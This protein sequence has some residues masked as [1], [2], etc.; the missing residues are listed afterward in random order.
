[1]PR[2]RSFPI[3]AAVA[4]ALEQLRPR[5]TVRRP[6]LLLLELAA[7]YFLYDAAVSPDWRRFDASEAACLFAAAFLISL[8]RTL[9]EAPARQRA[10]R[11]RAAGRGASTR[12]AF[13]DGSTEPADAEHLRRGDVIVVEA[14][15]IIPADGTVIEGAATV[16]ES[17]LTGESA[18][19]LREAGGER[20]SVI[21]GARVLSDVLKI[22]VESE[23]GKGFLADLAARLEGSL[24][25][26]GRREL[27]LGALALLPALLLLVRLGARPSWPTGVPARV[28]TALAAALL[29]AS[30][31][32]LSG[33]AGPSRVRRLLARGLLPR[34]AAALEAATRIDALILDEDDVAPEGRRRA[35][36]L[37]AAEGVP[38]ALLREAAQLT[39]LVDETP[40]GR[41]VVALAKSG[42]LRGR[43]LADMKDVR[44]VP[45]SPHTRVGGVDIGEA[46]YRKGPVESIRTVVGGF[47]PELSSAIDRIRLGGGDAIA[48]ASMGHALGLVHMRE[49]DARALPGRLAR[50]RAGG[51]RVILAARSD[52]PGSAALARELGADETAPA[53]DAE[54]RLALVRRERGAGRRVAVG[55]DRSSAAALAEAGFAVIRG[56]RELKS[57]DAAALD[58]EGDPMN[59][60]DAV[61]AGRAARRA[62]AGGDALAGLFDA[63]K[64]LAVAAAAAPLLSGAAASGGWPPERTALAA[65]AAG[66]AA[67]GALAL[68]ALAGL[69]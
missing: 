67:L 52:P 51:L 29:P 23:P 59:V 15:E 30:L 62:R 68:A 48:I 43:K 13:P 49:P 5:H 35:V 63:A 8:L 44:F 66:A 56:V 18:P 12:Q 69:S 46:V 33:A 16:D 37:I 41:S 58:L 10:V 47:S 61:E 39:S 7:A 64:A 17:A 34:D 54:S 11:W 14:G 57:C 3:V 28:W 50:L 26:A 25:A 24:L 60:V 19:V 65:A 31:A 1:M 53:A 36:E 20:A 4:A 40:E 2:P 9:S 22:R 55:G 6:A 21:A 32:G 38:E 27:A 42:S 45:R